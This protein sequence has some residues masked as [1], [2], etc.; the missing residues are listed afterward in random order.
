MARKQR[1]YKAEYRAAKLRATRAGYKSEREYKRVRRELALPRRAMPVPKRILQ[2]NPVVARRRE[3]QRWSDEHSRRRN[4]RYSPSMS[5]ADAERYWLAFV[6]PGIVDSE[7]HRRLKAFLVPL[8]VAP[9]D[10]DT[11]PSTVPLRR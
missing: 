7:K 10:W 3:S 8:R 4:S 1:D 2:A 5:D 9:D 6:E 11:N